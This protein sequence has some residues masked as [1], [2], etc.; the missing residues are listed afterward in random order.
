MRNLCGER[1]HLVERCLEPGKCV[2]DDGGELP[3]LVGR[4]LDRQALPEA[5]RCD[6]PG[7]VGHPIDWAES[8][9]RQPVASEARCG[10]TE[11]ESED[12]HQL[13]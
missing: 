5:L 3:E 6:H 7:P 1:L 8:A 9:A 2:I 11:G 4:I 13:A 12:E 10:D